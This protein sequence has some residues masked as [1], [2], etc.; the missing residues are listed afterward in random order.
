RDWS[1]DV[2]ASD[3]AP[4]DAV[5]AAAVSAGDGAAGPADDAGPDF[6]FCRSASTDSVVPRAIW[7][8]NSF[9]P[10]E[11]HSAWFR[12]GGGRKLSRPALVEDL[13]GAWCGVL[14]AR[15]SVFGICSRG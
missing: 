1:S 15:G 7:A 4:A 11:A 12:P 5:V 10:A 6:A 9:R 8:I 2:C 13:A 3:L 14:T